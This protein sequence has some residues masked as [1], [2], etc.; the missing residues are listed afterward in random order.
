MK[1][2]KQIRALLSDKPPKRKK[3]QK[4]HRT[5]KATLAG[6][7]IGWLLDI[8]EARWKNELWKPED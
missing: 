8:Q 3:A 1:G 6:L 7:V 2:L 5:A 4:K